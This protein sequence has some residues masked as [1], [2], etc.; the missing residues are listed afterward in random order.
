MT[1]LNVKKVNPSAK[2]VSVSLKVEVSRG[3]SFDMIE[4]QHCN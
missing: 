3:V 4:R 2:G 1:D